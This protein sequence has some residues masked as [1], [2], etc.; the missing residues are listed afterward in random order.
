MP[1]S[2]VNRL[3]LS[4]EAFNFS[5]QEGVD[6]RA[7]ARY[8]FYSIFYAVVGGDDILNQGNNQFSGTKATG[9]IGAGL[10]FTN[11]DLKLLLTKAPL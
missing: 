4:V 11:D 3:K 9:F 8:K 10:D 2:I 6:V 1:A 7:F 5:R